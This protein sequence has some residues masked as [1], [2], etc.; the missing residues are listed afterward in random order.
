MGSEVTLIVEAVS[1][2]WIPELLALFERAAIPCYCRFWHF[3]GNKNEWLERCA[4]RPEENANELRAAVE[5]GEETGLIARDGD[6]VV[7]WM[8]LAK[9]ARLPKLRRLAVYR[10]LD[11]GDEETTFSVGC[12]VVDPERRRQGVARALVAGAPAVA[13]SY[14]AKAIEGYPRHSDAPLYDEEAWQGPERVFMENGFE[15]VHAVPPYPVYRKV[16]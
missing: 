1:P 5:S 10:S 3:T 4:F 14:G 8:K 6:R 16:L 13:R 7:G 12:F 9:R 2:R 11:L 15:A